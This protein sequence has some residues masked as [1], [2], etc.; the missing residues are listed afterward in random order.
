MEYR[1]E[2]ACI[3]RDTIEYLE[4]AMEIWTEC[5]VGDFL[6]HVS[7]ETVVESLPWD[8]QTTEDQL[9]KDWHV[10]FYTSI[11]RGIHCYIMVHSCIEFVY[12]PGP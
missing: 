4:A 6:D 10:R 5:S 9:R 7:M 12:V 11:Y 3:N 8:N 1:F 2:T